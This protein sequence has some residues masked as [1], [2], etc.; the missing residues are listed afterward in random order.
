MSTC[1]LA[2][3][4]SEG[5]AIKLEPVVQDKSSRDPESCNDVSP[6]EPFSIYVSDVG[7]WLG[8][9][10]FGE[11]IRAD[12]QIPLISCCLREGAYNI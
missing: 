5:F 2:I 4:S 8:F 9:D 7:Q 11:V 1:L 10:P 12:Q 6:D 3:V